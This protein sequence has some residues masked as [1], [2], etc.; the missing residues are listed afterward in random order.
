MIWSQTGY[1]GNEIDILHFPGSSL[2]ENAGMVDRFVHSSVI[3]PE[4]PEGHEY[5]I[6]TLITENLERNSPLKFQLEQSGIPHLNLGAEARIREWT[7][8]RKPIINHR[9]LHKISTP[10]VL[11][12]DA[13]D[14]VIAGKLSDY[15][16]ELERKG[17]EILCNATTR[18]FPDIEVEHIENRERRFGKFCYLNAGV[19]FGKTEAIKHMYQY[20]VDAIPKYPDIDSE[21]FHVRC[22]WKDYPKKIGIDWECRVFQLVP[23]VRY[24]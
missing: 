7:R 19:M 2:S 12:L 21:Q 17:V 18:P 10:Y 16:P 15:V 8:S 3:V 6:A 24:W 11:M 4:I 20:I 14:V 23:R 13:R 5:T 9:N 1:Y 22:Y